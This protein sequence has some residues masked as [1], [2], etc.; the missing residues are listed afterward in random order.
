MAEN[1]DRIEKRKIQSVISFNKKL[2]T[3]VLDERPLCKY[4]QSCYQK[5]NIHLKK[6]RHPH[7]EESAALLAENNLNVINIPY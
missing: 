1:S 4:G 2:K 7:R 3:D 6:Y 5:N